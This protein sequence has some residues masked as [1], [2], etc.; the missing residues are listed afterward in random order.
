M[1][2]IIL[3]L[4]VVLLA[5]LSGCSAS[6]TVADKNLYGSTWQLEYISGPRIAFE[7]LFPENKPQ[8]TFAEKEKEVSGNSSCNGFSTSF[9]LNGNGIKIE[10]PKA[11]TMRFCEGGG[12]KV[13]LQM[14]EKV[15]KFSFDKDNK[16]NL[17]IDD[18]PMMRF[19]KVN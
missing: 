5:F 10:T 9:A 19:K 8:L 14:M 1:K 11:M 18:V 12:E 4:S 7:G 2:K 17:M 3:A 15:N 16:L 13:F 6:K